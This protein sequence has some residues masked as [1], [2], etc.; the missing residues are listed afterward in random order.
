MNT[1]NIDNKTQQQ[2][3]ILKNKNF[4]SLNRQN[5]NKHIKPHHLGKLTARERINLL[6][7]KNSFTEL[8]RFRV[9]RC[10]NFNIHKTQILGD[11]VITGFG[12]INNRQ[13]FAY[14]QDFTVFGGSL[15]EVHAQKICKIYDMAL[16]IGA[17]IIGMIDSG[18]ARIQEGV[19]ALAGYG[20]IFY[21]NTIASGV[22]PQISIIMG[23]SAGGAVYSPALT[24]F[25]LMIEKTSYMFLTGPNVIKEVTHEIISMEEL[26]GA[27]TNNKKSGNSHFLYKSDIE[28]IQGAK[29]LLSFL[30]NN[31]TEQPST[32]ETNIYHNKTLNQQLKNIIPSNQNKP[33]DIK[34]I[35]LCIIDNNSFLEIHKYFANNIV[36][37]FAKI[38]GHTV[39]I[40][41]NQP[42][43]LAGSLDI[44][45][46]NKA[47]RFIRI[48]DS[49]NIPII[50]LVDVPGFLP[51]LS[52]ELGGII[53]HGAKLLYAYSE[54]TVPKITIILRKAYG[55]A[56]CV[57]GSKHIGTDLN[58]ALPTAEIAVMG[59]KGAINILIKNQTMIKNNNTLNINNMLT[60][61]HDKYETP[62]VAAE[63]GYID[64][65]IFPEHIRAKLIQSLSI[66]EN[67]RIINLPK[68]HGN[69][70]L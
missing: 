14:A 36:I 4:L 2:R 15:S 30:P 67:K 60:E 64:E 54:A 3:D 57:M 68:K 25:T 28:A 40:V 17:P 35:I 61:Y 12:T 26:G 19:A 52:Q 5:K 10:Y 58:F 45:A 9:H 21:K 22:I 55:G 1:I 44:N 42:Q 63:L 43:V 65:I 50:T 20:E 37:G 49:F 39:G 47:A 53:R 7:D 6:F 13:I 48:C 23:A 24:D 56:Y 32:H 69:I 33:Y 11:G 62:Y 29:K 18:G 46:S 31:N 16:K 27:Y 34:S 70:P 38:N 41:G 51:G 59:A 66:L 8:D